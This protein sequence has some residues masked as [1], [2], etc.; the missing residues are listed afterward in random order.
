MNCMVGGGKEL[1]YVWQF[2]KFHIERNE[3]LYF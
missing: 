2:D 1:R 3:G